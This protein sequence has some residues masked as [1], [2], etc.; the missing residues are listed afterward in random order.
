MAS[1]DDLQN[2]YLRQQRPNDEEETRG[3]YHRQIEEGVH[4]KRSYQWLEKAGP[5]DSTKPLIMAGWEQEL[6]SRSIEARMYRTRQV[7]RYRLCKDAS[8]TVQHI[9]VGCKMKA[10][11][12]YIEHHNQVAGIVYLWQVTES[13]CKTPPKAGMP[14]L[15]CPGTFI[16]RL[17]KSSWLTTQTL[18]K[19]TNNS[20]RCGN[21]KRY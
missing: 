3:M 13:K 7:P 2:E 9:A 8:E 17:I 18:W 14:K 4:I 6:S 15:R 1:S 16:S 20:D 10:G 19:S 11:T 5:K 12:A 21:P